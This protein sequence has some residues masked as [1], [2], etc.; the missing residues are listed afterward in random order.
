LFYLY[1]NQLKVLAVRLLL[2]L[3]SK[4][5]KTKI[6]PMVN[7]KK[8]AILQTKQFTGKMDYNTGSAVCIKLIY[9]VN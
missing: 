7:E 2:I 1:V 9:D 5:I 3:Y 6:E 8:R 4:L